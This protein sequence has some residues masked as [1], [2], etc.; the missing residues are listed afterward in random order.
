MEASTPIRELELSAHRLDAYKAAIPL[1]KE[2]RPVLDRTGPEF[3]VDINDILRVARFLVG[4][5]PK[6]HV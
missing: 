4:D 2:A 3:G 6:E 1:V 5:E